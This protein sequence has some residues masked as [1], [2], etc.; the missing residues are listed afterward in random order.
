M[1]DYL[2]GVEVIDKEKINLIITD[3]DTSAIAVIGTKPTFLL[4]NKEMLNKVTTYTDSINFVG[5][6]LDEYTLPDACE[7]ILT[8]S[9]GAD[10][11]TINIFDET[12]HI[13]NV[14]NE[15]LTFANGIA[16][17]AHENP[18]NLE[19]KKGQDVLVEGTDYAINGNV[20]SVVAGGAIA[21]SQTNVKATYDYPDVTKITDSD[22][23]G[24]V[25][26][27]GNRS[28]IQAI[29]DIVAQYGVVPGIIIAPGFTSKNVR[30][31]METISET[32]KSFC[33]PDTAAVQSVS[34]MEQ[35]RLNPV[36]G[37]D[38]TSKSEF[39]TLLDTPVYRYNSYQ[40]TTTLKPLSPVVAG[41]RVKL[42]RKRSVA[43]SISNTL[44]KT[45]VGRKY[46]RSFKLNCSETDSNRINNLGM[47]TVI[48]YRGGYYI[49]G[50]RNSKYYYPTDT[51]ISTFESARQ[52]KN[53]IS[54]SIED[55]SFE[56][57][58]ETITRGFIDDVLN[59]INSKF[60]AWS[61]PTD[62][63]KQILLGGEAYW[64][65]SLN[66]AESLASGHIYFPFDYCM[67]PTAERITY[68]AVLDIKIIT[69][70]LATA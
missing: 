50:G 42:N 45:I 25:D 24:T 65:E 30:T 67:P 62:W 23:I 22:V 33:Y 46:N 9:G 36:N 51:S 2:H 21:S 10:I 1:S 13:T 49:W 17:L 5:N 11:Y 31:A 57:V 59:A 47:T 34:T 32:L 8:E 64:D 20:I 68:H 7:T 35:A 3:A 14:A 19:I 39:S 66:T 6:N 43:K 40:N 44:S 15:A 28:G 69:K 56:C 58:D 41:L 26:N 53:F 16:T 48:N 70:A 52:V 55:S 29:W 12:K 60:A 37:L 54:H 63:K 4:D 18:L 27:N 38:L 61:N